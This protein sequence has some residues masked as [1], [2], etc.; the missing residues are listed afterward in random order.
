M[1]GSSRSQNFKFIIRWSEFCF[2]LPSPIGGIHLM[3]TGVPSVVLPS[4]TPSPVFSE[5]GLFS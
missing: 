5:K 1:L 3:L 4:T 2:V